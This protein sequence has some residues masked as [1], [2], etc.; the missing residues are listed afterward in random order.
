[1][2][3][4]I[5][6]KQSIIEYNQHKEEWFYSLRYDCIFKHIIEIPKY[7]KYIIETLFGI[8]LENYEIRNAELNH[9]NKERYSPVVDYKIETKER[10]YIIEMQNRNGY[11]TA[12]RTIYS[13]STECHSHLKKGETYDKIKPITCLLILNYHYNQK[14]EQSKYQIQEIETRKPF[15]HI[16]E[17]QVCDLKESEGEKG[18]RGRLA[19][20]YNARRK[21]E[22]EEICQSEIEKEIKEE[23]IRYNMTSQDLLK[24]EEKEME[25]MFEQISLRNAELAGIEIGEER[26]QRKERKMVMRKMLEENMEI[27]LIQR[28]TG[29]TEEEIQ[30][31]QEKMKKQR[32]V[33]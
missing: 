29:C 17:I 30:K 24:I 1:M 23:I 9:D 25:E 19:K 8:Q 33:D 4:N 18:K 32:K 13:F 5:I 11:N 7:A 27:S 3:A 21:E 15:G 26:G 14:K 31:I 16:L 6:D 20:I 2:K 28:V 10:T 22:L 12:E